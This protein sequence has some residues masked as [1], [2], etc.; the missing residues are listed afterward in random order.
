ME[1]NLTSNEPSKQFT[2]LR[3]PRHILSSA[4]VQIEKKV[5]LYLKKTI[6]LEFEAI[7]DHQS[8]GMAMMSKQMHFPFSERLKNIHH[9]GFNLIIYCGLHGGQPGL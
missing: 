2:F 5:I 6:F 7:K 3:S 8:S 9:V 4:K 1:D